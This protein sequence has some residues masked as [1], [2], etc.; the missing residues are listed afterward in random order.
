MAQNNGYLNPFV[1]VCACVCER[2]RTFNIQNDHFDFEVALLL[3]GSRD[4]SLIAWNAET[5]K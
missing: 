3:P 1:C 4:S 2:E 5:L